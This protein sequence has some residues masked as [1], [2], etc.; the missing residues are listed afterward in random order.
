MPL[1]PQLSE[2]LRALP[3]R[4]GAGLLVDPTFLPSVYRPLATLARAERQDLLDHCRSLDWSDLATGHLLGVVDAI[5]LF[6]LLGLEAW[7]E[8]VGRTT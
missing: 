8:I 7:C 1:D 5:N 2:A 3:T 4:D 6:G